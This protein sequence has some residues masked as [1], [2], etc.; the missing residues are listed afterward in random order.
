MPGEPA[1]RCF[2]CSYDLRGIPDDRPCPECGLL[3]GRSRMPT[4]QL[5]HARP[6]W[7]WWLSTGVYLILAAELV[8]GAV[9]TVF[10]A[11]QDRSWNDPVRSVIDRWQ[12][13]KLL[14]TIACLLLFGGMMALTR[15]EGRPEVDQRSRAR[16]R[17]I[18]QLSFLPLLGLFLT[19]CE[20]LTY[21]TPRWLF[22]VWPYRL[23]LVADLLLNLPGVPLALLGCNYLR[24]LARR[25][26]DGSLAEHCTIVG[27]G[28]AV[29]LLGFSAMLWWEHESP[30]WRGGHWRIVLLF[31]FILAAALFHLWTTFLMLRFAVRFGQAS[32]ASRRAW[33]EADVLT[34]AA[35]N[36][37]P[38]RTGG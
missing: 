23:Y 16:R 37:K 6:R 8:A 3:A 22:F 33:A 15:P 27:W 36:A 11:M 2:R 30:A 13:Q 28:W 26:L 24:S 29:S 7:L 18:R 5:R 17:L 14:L 20:V 12:V 4:D 34:G 25:E 9:V 10:W 35:A 32:S 1:D 31:V 21:L 38:A 19:W